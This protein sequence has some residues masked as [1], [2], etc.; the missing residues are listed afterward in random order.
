MDINV[1]LNHM[2][3]NMAHMLGKYLVCIDS[4]L[5]MSSRLD[6]LVNNLPNGSFKVQMKCFFSNAEFER[7]AKIR[8]ISVY[9]FLISLLVPEL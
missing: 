6:K 5:L 3:K 2:E 1:I 4:L 7:V 8:K 9:R